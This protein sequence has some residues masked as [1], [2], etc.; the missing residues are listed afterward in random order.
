MDWGRVKSNIEANIDLHLANIE[1]LGEFL[2]VFY[3][4]FSIKSELLLAS[5]NIIWVYKSDMA[6]KSSY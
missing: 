5:G 1:F 6:L 3:T 4:I 2:F